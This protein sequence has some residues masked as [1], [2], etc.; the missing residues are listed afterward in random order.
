MPRYR[1]LTG[2]HA[3]GHLREAFTYLVQA[4]YD[5]E[6]GQEEGLTIQVGW[7][8]TPRGPEWILGQLWNCTDAMPNDVVQ[9]IEEMSARYY[10]EAHLSRL[11]YA[12]GARRLKDLL[13]F[14][15]EEVAQ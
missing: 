7:D 14:W 1:A 6:E 12:T 5:A 9:S 13:T 11:T 8:E 15:K 2:G 3:P 4:L 10:D